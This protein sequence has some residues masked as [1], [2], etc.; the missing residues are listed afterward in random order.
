MRRWS[1]G[2]APGIACIVVAMLLLS[3]QDGLIKWLGATYAL[4]QI[5]LTRSVI[6]TTLILLVLVATARLALL[7]TRRWSLHV[8]RGLLLVASNSTFFLG[9]IAMPIA[10][11]VAMFFVAPLFITLLSALVLGERVGPRRL[12]AV[13]AGFAGVVVVVRPGSGLFGFTALLPVAAAATYAIMQ[14][15][16]RRLGA[17]D[18]AVG[19]A[20]SVQMVFIAASVGMGLVAGDGRFAGSDDPSLTFLLR[21]WRL[22]SAGDVP[23]LGLVGLLTAMASVLMSQA[24]RSTAPATIA[25][26]E[27]IALPF[28]AAWGFLFWGEVPDAIAILG[29]GLIIG[30]G[31]FIVVRT[32]RLRTGVATPTGIATADPPSAPSD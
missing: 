13:L 1:S 19:M 28:A 10:E 31:V 16:T 12:L 22:P 20:F 26:F 23:L 11:A 7:R 29:M 5:V 24:Y 30:S 18:S 6:A 15:L 9:L 8:A 2:A 32:E 27:Y 17:T 4:H 21:P 3:L 14:I 25:P